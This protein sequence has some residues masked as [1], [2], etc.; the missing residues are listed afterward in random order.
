MSINQF[1]PK[2]I[3]ALNY[4]VYMLIDPRDNKAF[5]IG[6]GK[7][8]RVFQHL[9]C[10]LDAKDEINAK[11]DKIIDIRKYGLEVKH[12]I[13]RHGIKD[14]VEAYHIEASLIDTLIYCGTDLSNIVSGH[15]SLQKGL[16]TTDEIIRL[17]NAEK[18]LKI[19][20][21]CVIIN[22]NKKYPKGGIGLSIYDATKETWT[23]SKKKLSN[24]KFVLS[25][26]KGLIVEVF[27][28]ESWYEKDRG[29]TTK[30][31]KY[32]QTKTGYGFKGTVANPNVRDLYINKSIQHTKKKGA[33]S[34][35]RFQI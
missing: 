26:Y 7:E 21:D 11:Y 15:N 14:E 17:Y 4:Y 6:K 13:I 2:T 27:E 19:N 9:K 23:I 33:A 24:I 20:N 34:V 12:V 3:L 31:K 1:D 16:M 8:N 25:E 30:S 28:V 10:A 29:Y 35:I 32:G 22:I 18:L 5:Y